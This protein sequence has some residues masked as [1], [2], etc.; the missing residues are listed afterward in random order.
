MAEKQVFIITEENFEQEVLQS[1][2]PVLIDFW[3]VWCGPCR[4]IAPTVEQLAE[5]LAGRIKVC[6]VNV[7][8]QPGLASRYGVMS[9]P[10]L[11]LVSGQRVLLKSIGVKPKDVLKHDIEAVL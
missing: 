4:M 11:A 1:D 3:A 2:I 7:D 6:K 10:T 8:E 5:E 9:I